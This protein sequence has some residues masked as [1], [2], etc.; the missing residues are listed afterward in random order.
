MARRKYKVSTRA[1]LKHQGAQFVVTPKRDFSSLAGSLKSHITL[2]NAQLAK[3]R[4]RFAK[5]WPHTP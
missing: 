1:F 4:K 3:T 5:E 2:G